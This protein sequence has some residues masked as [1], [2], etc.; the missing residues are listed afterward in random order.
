MALTGNQLIVALS[1]FI[2]DYWASTTTSNGA[3]DGSTVI[4]T[5][6]QRFGDQAKDNAYVRLLT[7][8]SPT[9]NLNAVRRVA[10]GVT[11]SLTVTPAFPQE[12]TS[13]VSYELHRYDPATKFRALDRARILAFP[14][15]AKIVEDETLT[16]DGLTTE[17][18]IPASIRRGPAQVWVEFPLPPT[19]R[20][21][22]APNQYV[23]DTSSLSTTS[24]AVIATYSRRTNDLIIPKM[25]TTCVQITSGASGTVYQSLAAASMAGRQCSFGCWIYSRDT[26]ATVFI[27]D[28]SGTTSSSAHGGNGW[29]F[30][31]V[32]KHIS[33]SNATTLKFGITPGTNNVMY[34]E[35][36]FFG[37]VPNIS[38]EFVAGPIP[39][40][41]VYRDDSHAILMLQHPAARGYQ[42]RLVGRAPITALGTDTT[43]QTANTMEVS[44]V[45]QDL[46]LATAA[47][48]LFTWEG[49][50]T[51]EIDQSMPYIKEVEDRFV[52]MQEDWKRRYPRAG[53]IEGW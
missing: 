50:A 8:S 32:Q 7:D 46:L 28:D 48:L 51:G 6:L 44:E 21:N 53:F 20:W 1:Q 40:R 42:Y 29:Q 9:G 12:V 24:G 39:R 27:T 18:L 37:D 41:G 14:Q 52:E 23:Q 49:M 38:L 15:V 5:A 43:T 35:R 11:N 2:G 26:T 10:S 17:I 33:G 4:D 34:T 16:S 36:W 31:Q 47:R 19:I 30:L 25:N 22:V 13:S 45:D 3:S